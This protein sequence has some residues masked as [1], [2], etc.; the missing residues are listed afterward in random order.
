MAR[1]IVADIQNRMEKEMTNEQ[2]LALAGEPVAEVVPIKDES[3]FISIKW[4]LTPDGMLRRPMM[5]GDGLFTADQLLALAGELKNGS[6]WLGGR[7]NVYSYNRAPKQAAALLEVLAE[8]SIG[9]LLAALRAPEAWRI[10]GYGHFKDVTSKPSD[11]PFRAADVIEAFYHAARKPL[12]EIA[13]LK[14]RLETVLA[15]AEKFLDSHEECTDFDG[16][17][18]QIVSMDDY[19]EAQDAIASVKESK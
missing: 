19:H 13:K 10:E 18:A 8:I 17:T 11:A 1:W 3:G 7:S 16:F 2:I 15:A 6:N 4:I 12:E 9:D 14:Q 5:Y